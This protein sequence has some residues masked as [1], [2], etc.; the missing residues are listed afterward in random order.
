[1]DMKCVLPVL[2]HFSH[3]YLHRLFTQE[4]S[5]KELMQEKGFI[6]PPILSFFPQT[7][8]FG[9]DT[10]FD[11]YIFFP[12]QTFVHFCYDRTVFWTVQYNTCKC[13][14][15]REIWKREYVIMKI[16]LTFMLGPVSF[17]SNF[18]INQIWTS[19]KQGESKN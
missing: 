1:M 3:S 13:P 10:F 18:K 7:T 8:H 4:L 19:V 6:A 14:Y 15:W 9:L 17:Q 5:Q 11:I 16:D 2:K 12:L